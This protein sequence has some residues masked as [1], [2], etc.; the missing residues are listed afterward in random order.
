M[1]W[2]RSLAYRRSSAAQLV[3]F[4][5]R[6]ETKR[7]GDWTS[8]RGGFGP[9]GEHVDVS[10]LIVAEHLEELLQE[11]SIDLIDICL[12]AH[13]HADAV[14]KVLAAGKR[15]LCEKPLAIHATLADQLTTLSAGDGLMVAH[16]LPFMPPYAYLLEAARD[17]RFGRCVTGRF[18]RTISPPDRA[19]EYYDPQRM[20]GPL[21]DLQVD[22]AQIIRLL[23]GIPAAA[24]TASHQMPTTGFLAGVPKRYETVFE[25][26]EFDQEYSSSN[27]VTFAGGEA[28]TTFGPVVS[29]GGGV[30][31]SPG[32]RFSQGFEVGFQ[33][34][35]LR[36][37]M[38]LYGDGSIEQTGLT[39]LYADG[40]VERPELPADDPIEPYRR[41][42]DAA[43]AVVAGEPLP[44][45]LDP[46]IAT[47]ALRICEMQMPTP[48]RVA[49]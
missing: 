16:P 14:Q 32:R 24:H 27:Q 45:A 38:S 37:E 28:V 5:S 11:D 6:S 44:S 23:Y 22:D 36:Y 20:G 25:Y 12:P 2:I 1:G 41:Q 15:V 34:A 3:G 40:K 4:A 10:N 46:A 48:L 7:R 42:V 43:A 8:I 47:D 17:G 9:P 19:S 18:D 26:P 13:L 35:V 31:D 33:Q 21:I 29:V 30:I 49:P 39:I